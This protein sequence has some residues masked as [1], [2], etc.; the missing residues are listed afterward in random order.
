MK[1]TFLFLLLLVW[2]S[3]CADFLDEQSKDEVIPRTTQDLDELLLGSGYPSPDFPLEPYLTIMDDDVTFNATGIDVVGGTDAGNYFH[4]Y[5]WQPDVYERNVSIPGLSSPSTYSLYYGRIKGCNAVLDYIDGVAGPQA[6]KDRVKA[7]ALAIRAFLYFNLVNLY[8]KPYNEDKEAA[9]VPLKLSASITTTGLKRNTVAEVYA[10]LINDLN[11]AIAFFKKYDVTRGNYRINLPA[12]CILLS[13]AYLY[14]EN[15]QEAVVAASSAMQYGSPLTNLTVQ[16]SGFYILS[17]DASETEW[18]YGANEILPVV[19]TAFRP[20]SDLLGQFPEN[21]KR[22]DLYISA[23]RERS[24]K[25]ASGVVSTSP[26][27]GIRMAEAYLNRAEAYAQLGKTNESLNDLN[28]LRSQRILDYASMTITDKELLIQAVRRERRL[29]LC[30]EGHRWFDLRRYG[31][32]AITHEFQEKNS[33]P[34][35]YT[36]QAK[37]AMYTLPIP[38][39]ALKGN[40]ALEQNQ[41][42]FIPRRTGI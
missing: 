34:Q 39:E 23:D 13:R 8:G 10:Q 12:T 2:V 16:S 37:D 35:V 29:E 4:A 28:Q 6:Q 14:M 42:A 32:P 31:M 36:L 24:T 25:E 33:P 22:L 40:A 1:K 9:G 41:S 19:L 5:T 26:Y 38:N 30:Y 3:S 27:R 15:W 7:E 18:L 21:D 11:A 20:S 17:R